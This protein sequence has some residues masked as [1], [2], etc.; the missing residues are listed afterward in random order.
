[1]NE[2]ISRRLWL[3]LPDLR[4][5]SHREAV[6][7]LIAYLNGWML[8]NAPHL[9]SSLPLPKG[10]RPTFDSNTH[11]V[12]VAFQ[13]AKGLNDNGIVERTTWKKLLLF[14]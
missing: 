7:I 3:R 13:K 2:F 11:D 6:G 1:V 9:L 8:Q 12:V 4:V 10:S 5:G 14:L